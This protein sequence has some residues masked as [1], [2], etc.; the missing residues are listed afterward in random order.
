MSV[1]E[2]REGRRALTASAS[3]HLLLAGALLVSFN[4]NRKPPPPVQVELWAGPPVV[5]PEPPAAPAPAVK[6]P[7]PKPT[8]KAP[9]PAPSKAD[10]ALKKAAPPKPDPKELARK[11]EEKRAAEEQRLEEL[12]REQQRIEQ[13]RVAQEKQ[14]RQE[15]LDKLRQAELARLSSARNAPPSQEGRDIATKAGVATGAEIGSKTGVDPDYAALIQARIKARIQYADRTSDN[16]EAVVSVE[17][18]PTGEITQ[19]QLVKPSGVAAWDAAVI[20]A[21]RAA[22]PLPKRKDGTV[23]RTL[24]LSFRPKETP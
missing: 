24:E 18:L 9:P 7:P 17:Q 19:V 2:Q 20:R 4:W 6:A 10:I 23:A 22:S 5:I 16:P 3:V 1:I 21:I 13:E 15:K 8:P 11:A 12:R 14:R